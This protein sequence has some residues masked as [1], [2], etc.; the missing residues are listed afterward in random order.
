MTLVKPPPDLLRGVPREI[1]QMLDALAEL[2]RAHPIDPSAPEAVK[3]LGAQ[4]WALQFTGATLI[5]T[6]PVEKAAL[7]ELFVEQAGQVFD[8]AMGSLASPIHQ[9]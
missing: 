8:L 1:D 6:A 2:L 7:R 4:V 9:G 3:L 5:N